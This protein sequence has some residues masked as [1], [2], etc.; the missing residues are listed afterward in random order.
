MQV[1]QCVVY[2]E[3]GGHWPSLVNMR[4]IYHLEYMI[5]CCKLLPGFSDLSGV[6]DCVGDTTRNNHK[7]YEG[8]W[9]E[10]RVGVIGLLLISL[11][12]VYYV[13]SRITWCIIVNDWAV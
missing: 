3:F 9:G 8:M 10:C 4:V 11:W 1:K 7:T 2:G 6:K 13:V 5:I 12:I